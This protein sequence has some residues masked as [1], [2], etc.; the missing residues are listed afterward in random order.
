VKLVVSLFVL[1]SITGALPAADPNELRALVRSATSKFSLGG[2]LRDEYSFQRRRELRELDAAGKVRSTSVVVS[3]KSIEAGFPVTR[4]IEKDGKP[5]PSQEKEKQEDTIRK[6]LAELRAL[7]PAQRDERRRESENKQ[8]QQNGFLLELPDAMEFKLVGEETVKGRVTTVLDCVPRPGYQPKNIK[9]KIFEK[10]KARLWID[11]VDTELIKAEGEVFDTVNIGWGIL[12]RIEKG[13]T[14]L[15]ERTK[16]DSG[17]WALE[18]Q[19][20]RFAVRFMLV[21]NLNQEMDV[22]YS[23]YR[24]ESGPSAAIT[25]R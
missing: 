9:A 4:V 11:K 16:I 21:K 2:T 14:F 7:T 8:A 15:V 12:G 6:R 13:T 23:N 5:L 19:A 22:R 10:T 20:T 3:Q 17:V 1:S 25:V 24:K 18:H